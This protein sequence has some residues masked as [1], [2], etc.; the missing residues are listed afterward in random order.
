MPEFVGT[1]GKFHK[2]NCE[3][4]VC[5]VVSQTF[6]YNILVIIF[7]INMFE[8]LDFVTVIFRYIFKSFERSDQR[9]INIVLINVYLNHFATPFI[10][11]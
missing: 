1:G 8:L 2:L 4:G 6:I 7:I 11:Y 5:E 9:F 3:N 10:A